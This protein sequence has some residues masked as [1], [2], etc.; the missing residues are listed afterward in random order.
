M[1]AWRL[2][3]AAERCWWSQQCEVRLHAFVMCIDGLSLN[4]SAIDN[5]ISANLGLKTREIPPAYNLNEYEVGGR[6]WRALYTCRLML[7]K[8]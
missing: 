5:N 7:T 1:Y 6:T 4:V 2:A 3:S 8:I